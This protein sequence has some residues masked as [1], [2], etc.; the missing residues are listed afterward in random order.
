MTES[1]LYM[2]VFSEYGWA[3]CLRRFS[4]LSG[5]QLSERVLASHAKITDISRGDIIAIRPRSFC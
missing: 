2:K 4:D 5:I 1:E 3:R